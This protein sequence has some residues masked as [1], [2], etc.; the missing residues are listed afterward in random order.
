M[1]KKFLFIIT[2]LFLS[3]SCAN[4]SLK[5]KDDKLT[6]IQTYTYADEYYEYGAK[7]YFQINNNKEISW[8]LYIGTKA[9]PNFIYANM[10]YIFDSKT[11]DKITFTLTN[12]S[13]NIST[14]AAVI[15]EY[16]YI[17]S[18]V[19]CLEN[20]IIQISETE[21]KELYRI[22]TNAKSVGLRIS[23]RE[24]QEFILSSSQVKAMIDTIEYYNNEFNN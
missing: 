16:A 13:R 4:Y 12:V 11:Y 23:G 7:L 15:N 20:A 3:I 10:A 5:V 24:Y 22:L 6:G 21:V 14:T 1:L 17:P 2:I 19:N 18:Q 9:M 8:W